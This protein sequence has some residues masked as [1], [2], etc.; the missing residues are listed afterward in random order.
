MT[1]Q[2]VLKS[3]YHAS[4]A[5]LRDAIDA[6][7]AELWTDDSYVNQFWQV[8]YHTLFYT[9]LY[10]QPS[11]SAFVAWKHHRPKYNFFPSGPEAQALTPYSIDDVRA[12]CAHC[13]ASIDAAVDRLD[14][15]S[16]DSGFPWYKMSK[17]EH[18]LVSLRHIQHH[19]GQLAE[20]IRQVTGRG[21]GWVGGSKK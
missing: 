13:E 10:L 6:C 2:S 3:Q 18:Q 14:L 8:A 9:D 1:I 16:P 11:E 17:L 19:T 20:R 4:V 15:T 7:P 12:Y 21:V 5:M